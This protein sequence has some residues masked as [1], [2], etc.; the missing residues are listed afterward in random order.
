MSKM[1]DN[2]REWIKSYRSGRIWLT[3]LESELTVDTY[4][5]NFKRFCEACDLDPD[6][7][8]ELKMKGMRNVGTEKEFC[9]EE[10][11]DITIN[12]LDATESA[13]SN[14]S[15]SVLSFYKH[16]RRPLVEPKKFERPEPEKQ[17]PSV[18]EIEEMANNVSWKRDKALI[19]FTASAPFREGTLGKLVWG[20]L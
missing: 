7:L 2:L 18:T 19:W 5:P 16:N 14:I 4:L 8:I 6:Q 10:N 12:E 15:T 1:L 17:R 3:K 20:D 9:A 13:K 11:F